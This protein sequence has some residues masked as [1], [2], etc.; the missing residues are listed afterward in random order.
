[1]P[2]N[3]YFIDEPAVI[4]FSGGRTSAYMLYKILEAH[5]GVLPDFVKVCFANTGKEMPQ[6]LDFVRDC[7]EQWGVEIVWLELF[8]LFAPGGRKPIE[9]EYK[10]TNYS[11]A[12]RNGEP[13]NQLLAGMD[14]IPNAVTRTCTPNLKIRAMKWYT[15]EILQFESPW[16]QYV[17]LRSDE[18]H[19][20][21]KLHGKVS[22]GHEVVCPL[23][24]DG[25][26]AL[27]VGNFWSMQNFDLQLPNVNGVTDWGNCD[28]C[29]LKSKSKRLSIIRER[30]DLADWWIAAEKFKDQQFR[31]DEVSY[32][33]M[34]VF[35]TDQGQLFDFDDET[36]PCFCGD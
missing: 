30:P 32:E 22:E 1:M 12:S 19:R 24:I 6:T 8:R 10:I 33:R 18:P 15:T 17:G 25:V 9:R 26:T 35:A 29:F 7:S 28:V 16:L 14:A 36:I 5:D 21:R 13:F 11:E 20:S 2:A 4:S 31:P 34:K 3:P 27:D 23:F